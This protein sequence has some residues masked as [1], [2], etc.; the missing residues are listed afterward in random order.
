MFNE[1]CWIIFMQ[2]LKS[3]CFFVVVGQKGVNHNGNKNKL[4]IYILDDKYATV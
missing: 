4:I 2:I 3:Y 1:S